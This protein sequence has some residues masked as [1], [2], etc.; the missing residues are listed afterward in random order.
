MFKNLR[1]K[2]INQIEFFWSLV[3]LDFLID[4]KCHILVQQVSLQHMN[5]MLLPSISCSGKLNCLLHFQDLFKD[6]I[7]YELHNISTRFYNYLLSRSE[8]ACFPLRF[9]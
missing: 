1:P 6:I 5:F 3:M 2:I 8:Q 4:L 9:Q 7:Q